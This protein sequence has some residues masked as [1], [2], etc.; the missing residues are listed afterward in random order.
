MDEWEIEGMGDIE[1]RWA[2]PVRTVHIDCLV[3]CGSLGECRQ[4]QRRLTHWMK[5]LP[6]EDLGLRRELSWMSCLWVRWMRSK[7][8]RAVGRW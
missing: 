2:S 8:G 7:C 6:C 5:G 1:E 3:D 4:L